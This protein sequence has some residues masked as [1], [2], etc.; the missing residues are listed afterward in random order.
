[1][2]NLI[3]NIYYVVSIGLSVF[4]C[5]AIY[6]VSKKGVGNMVSYGL[7]LSYILLGLSVLVALILSAKGMVDKP[8]SALMSGI[9]LAAMIVVIVIG[10]S[11]DNHEL[12]DNYAEYGVKT[13]GLSGLIGGSLIATY[14]IMGLAVAL[15]LYAAVSD[16]IKRL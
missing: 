16:F 12:A 5:I 3:K 13:K 9:G 15:A 14:I 8:K 6:F 1:M 4:F 7:I 2:G 11:L 10:Y